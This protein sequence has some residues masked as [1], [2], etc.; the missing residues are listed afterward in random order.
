MCGITGF[1]EFKSKRGKEALVEIGKD[2][3]DSLAHR[4][5]DADGL[6]QDPVV[7]LVLTHR[8]LS[9]IDLSAQGA[10]PMMSASERYVITF[11]GEIYNFLS[12]RKELEDTAKVTFRGHSDTEVILAAIDHWGLNLTLQ[13]M[14]GM[15]A[16]VIWDRRE[17]ELHFVRDRLGKKPLYVGWSGNA[18]VFASELKALRAH[19]DFKPEIRRDVLALFMRYAYVPAPH[20]IYENVWSLP[21]GFRLTLDVDQ[22]KVGSDLQSLMK[23]YW[24]HLRVLEE[25]RG[26][27]LDK[28]DKDIADEFES[29]LSLCISERMVSDVPLGAFLSGGIDS[30]AVV[31]L[32]QKQSDRPVKTYSI[33][34]K[35]AGFN[36]AEH[37]AKIASHLGT[38]HHEMMLS[39]D[40]ARSLVPYMAGMYD[41]PFADISAIPT[42][43]V[44]QFARKDVTV[45]LSGDGGDEMLGGYNRHIVGPKLW[46]R[47]KL[48]PAPMRRT[49]ANTITGVS[50]STWDKLLAPISP[51]GGER[52]HKAAS[53]MAMKSQDEVFE[54]LM[55]HW[56]DPY[57]L[58]KHAPETHTLLSIS[59][60]QAGEDLSFAE[61]MMY[62]DAL[63]YLPN[64]ILT[65][66]DR[67]SMAVALEARAPLLDRRIYEYVWRLP[68][69]VKIRNGRGKWLLREVLSRHVPREM[70]ERP[71][72]GFTMPAGEWM[73]GS[74]K[75][76]AE[77]LINET[78]LKDEGYMEPSLI[79]KVWDEHQAGQGQHTG[80]L[81][82]VLMFQS[83][84]DRW[85]K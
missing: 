70:F 40:D 65:K 5:P 4:G 41:E 62:G 11:N 38:D 17:K 30:S 47:M 18:L 37:A 2:M 68:E 24:H 14:N 34:F 9:I 7:P 8:R 60:W 32:M 58:V 15:F 52:I 22:A 31:A 82:N 49:I 23:P 63:S 43:L 57:T 35:E 42:F 51:Q 73:R 66:V 85:M 64:D 19:P 45:A 56:H 79:R 84:L 10:Q 67:A 13:K 27:S 48:M 81:W 21:A 50:T 69:K 44:S 26:L 54:R 75:D 46:K 74:L 36:E 80:K 25:A 1:Y 12:L 61:R 39:A 71:K 6:W 77:D 33:G 76:W 16:L 28:S 59:E 3:A 29:L 78:R 53:V 20:C 83:W 55:S 72:Q